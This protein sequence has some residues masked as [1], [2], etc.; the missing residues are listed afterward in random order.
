MK[1]SN[2][3]IYDLQVK[4]LFEVNNSIALDCLKV[5]PFE[6]KRKLQKLVIGNHNYL[7]ICECKKGE[8]VNCFK[9]ESQSQTDS[10]QINRVV[11]S[12]A[13]EDKFSIFYS[14]G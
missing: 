9:S 7:E 8:K 2:H 14:V 11:V 1:Q 4:T 6:P 5:L 12:I 13:S 10:Q 3:N